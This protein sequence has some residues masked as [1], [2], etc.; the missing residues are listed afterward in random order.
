MLCSLNFFFS[1]IVVQ[2]VS[3]SLYKM[4]GRWEG[5]N[6]ES[7]FRSFLVGTWEHPRKKIDLVLVSSP[8]TAEMCTLLGLFISR[9]S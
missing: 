3:D 7:I 8:D 2:F 1:F 9:C 5:V 6:A 4:M